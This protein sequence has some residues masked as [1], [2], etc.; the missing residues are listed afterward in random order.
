MLLA[1]WMFSPHTFSLE[2]Q[3][4][5]NCLTFHQSHSIR[6]ITQTSWTYIIRTL[7]KY[8]PAINSAW[9]I[10]WYFAL[11]DRQFVLN[12][13]YLIVIPQWSYRRMFGTGPGDLVLS[14]K[15]RTTE[16][17][18]QGFSYDGWGDYESHG[19]YCEKDAWCENAHQCIRDVI[20]EGL[21]YIR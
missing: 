6:T 3:T 15:Q 16:L 9:F 21:A 18:M 20:T 2:S 14:H 12:V 8:R 17:A 5:R 19:K 10:L 13:H 1:Q 7:K 11:R 4:V